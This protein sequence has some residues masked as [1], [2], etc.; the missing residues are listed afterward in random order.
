MNRS[1]AALLGVW[2]SLNTVHASLIGDEITATWSYEFFNQSV[3]LT[4][5]S[6]P[7]SWVSEVVI[8]AQADKIIVDNIT[9]PGDGLAAGVVWSFTGIDWNGTPGGILG[10]TANTN[11]VGWDSSFLSFGTDS[12]TVSFLTDV[13]TGPFTN[14]LFELQITGAPTPVPLPATLPLFLMGFTALASA[15]RILRGRK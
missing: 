7:V 13:V 8:E 3:L 5:G 11:Y 1:I 2:M 4:G 10:V 15:G 9:G 12:I 14:D 6:G